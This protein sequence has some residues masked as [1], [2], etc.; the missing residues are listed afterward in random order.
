MSFAGEP[1]PSCGAK[2]VQEDPSRGHPSAADEPRGRETRRPDPDSTL[3]SS[4]LH[5]AVCGQRPQV[6]HQRR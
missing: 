5:Q 3:G 1:E 4:A 6:W 2:P